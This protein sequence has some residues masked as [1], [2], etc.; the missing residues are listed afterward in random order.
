MLFGLLLRHQ[1]V[2]GLSVATP[3]SGSSQTCDVQLEFLLSCFAGRLGGSELSGLA[4]GELGRL[5]GRRCA[6]TTISPRILL[7]LYLGIEV[8]DLPLAIATLTTL[9]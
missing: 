4:G 2:R 6:V 5:R 9:V 3:L 1:D 8:I 7:L